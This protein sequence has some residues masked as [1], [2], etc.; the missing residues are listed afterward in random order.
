MT[1][2]CPGRFVNGSFLALPIG[3]SCRQHFASS[4]T[5]GTDSKTRPER[6]TVCQKVA[7]IDVFSLVSTMLQLSIIFKTKTPLKEEL[8]MI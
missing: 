4:K 8:Q 3:K 6:G 7:L 5:P 1:L 2:R